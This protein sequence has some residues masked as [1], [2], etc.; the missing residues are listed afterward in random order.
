MLPLY[1]EFVVKFLTL[2]GTLRFSLPLPLPVFMLEGS[3]TNPHRFL[4]RISDRI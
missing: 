1:I 2:I 4:Q 3:L